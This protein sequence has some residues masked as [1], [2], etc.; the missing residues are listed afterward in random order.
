MEILEFLKII[1]NTGGIVGVLSITLLLMMLMIVSY[2]TK[3]YLDTISE[4]V[5]KYFNKTKQKDL[6]KHDLFSYLNVIIS[7]Q[8]HILDI[9]C[10]LRNKVFKKLLEIKLSNLRDSLLDLI[11]NIKE[12]NEDVELKSLFD[13]IFIQHNHNWVKIAKQ[14][15]LPDIAITKFQDFYTNYSKPLETIIQDLTSSDNILVD[16]KNQMLNIIFEVIKAMVL[17]S[18]LA[19]EKTLN[20][21]NG[22]LSSVVFEGEKCRH[23]GTKCDYQ[24]HE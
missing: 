16:D 4:K 19:A 2:L 20:T 22:E 15:N 14:N 23:C 11:K 7:H 21:L 17:S 18:L 8:I 9:K 5:K 10:P 3:D 13:T 1:W 6:E 12:N 24:K